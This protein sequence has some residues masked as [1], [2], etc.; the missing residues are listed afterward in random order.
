MRKMHKKDDRRVYVGIDV[1]KDKLNVAWHG[2]DGSVGEF[3]VP[4]DDAGHQEII[5]RI[6][7]GRIHRA[8]VVM[9]ATGPYG[10]RLFIALASNCAIEVMVVRPAA[11]KQFGKATN[12]R[13]KT[14]RVDALMLA[15]YA[16]AVEF[17]PTPIVDPELRKLRALSRHMGELIVRRASV[18][19]QRHAAK[20]GL[21]ASELLLAT[22]DAEEA[23]LT[24]LIDQLE[25]AIIT[26]IKSLPV[27]KAAYSRL[28]RI[29]GI[30]D[31]T[32]ARLLPELMCMPK[33]LTTRQCIAFAG[34]DPRPN[35]SGTSR[36][37]THWHISK[38]GNPRVRQALY[39]A[40]LSSVRWFPPLRAF[41]TRLRERGKLKM[42]ALIAAMRKL[43]TAA[44]AITAHGQEFD[45]AKFSGPLQVAA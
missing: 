2:L 7:A 28:I 10:D 41:Y 30:K 1:S 27:A 24:R 31:R 9:E 11:A 39:M 18:L 37:G 43:L 33:H 15:A 3:E 23:M 22:L 21:D 45:E 12:R 29:Q 42:V 16:K 6:T 26:K 4:N 19:N 35:Q 38:Q 20:V 36:A 8:R 13:A 44:W 25:V 32:A 14:D 34:L 40:V 17:K 5:A